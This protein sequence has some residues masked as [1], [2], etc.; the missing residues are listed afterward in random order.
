MSAS[1]CDVSCAGAAAAAA[2]G[3]ETDRALDEIDDAFCSGFE[4]GAGWPGTLAGASDEG[5]PVV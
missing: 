4:T 5:E 1:S 2:L 3:K